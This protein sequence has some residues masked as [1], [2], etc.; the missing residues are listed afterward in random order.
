MTQKL[1][2]YVDESGQDTHGE[3]FIVAV[4]ITDDQRE[5]LLSALEQIERDSGKGANKWH[6]TMPQRRLDYIAAVLKLM[7]REVPMFRLAFG[8]KL[9]PVD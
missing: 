7:R 4:V 3:L 9:D 1:Y 8:L 2:C 5:A 6:K